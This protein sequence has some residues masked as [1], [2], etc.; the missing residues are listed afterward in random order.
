[1]LE[2]TICSENYKSIQDEMNIRHAFLCK[3]LLSKW[4]MLTHMHPAYV[5]FM[6]PLV[7]VA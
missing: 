2:S 5:I 3:V 1:M 6:R 4:R 7:L